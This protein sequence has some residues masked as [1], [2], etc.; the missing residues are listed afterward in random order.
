MQCYRRLASAWLAL[1]LIG[2]SPADEPA[3]DVSVPPDAAQVDNSDALFAP[4]RVLAIEITLP[5]DDWDAL[6]NQTRTLTDIL[7]GDCLAQP[8]ADV[9]TYFQGDISID[10]VATTAVGVRKKGFLGSLSTSK[11][12]LKVRFDKFVEGQHVSGPVKR[13]T[14]NNVRQD[15]SKLNTCL[16]YAVFAAAGVPAPRCGFAHV[17]VNGEDLGLYVHIDSTKKPF[18]RRHF[19]SDEGNLYEGTISDFTEGWRGTFQKKTNREQAD[20]VDIGALVEALQAFPGADIATLSQHVDLEAFYT[21]WALEVLVGHWDSYSGN[22]NN[23][24]FYREPDGPFHFLPWGADSTFAP[25]EDHLGNDQFP[26]AVLAHGVI[27][28]HLYADPAGRAAFVARLRE[29]LDTVWNEA[30]LLGELERMSDQVLTHT[31]GAEKQQAV[32]DY[33]R[34]KDFMEGRRT[35]IEASLAEDGADWDIP[36]DEPL[37]CWEPI[38]TVDATFTAE[39]GTAG[40]ENPLGLGAVTTATFDLYGEPQTFVSTGATA[41]SQTDENGTAGTVNLIY[42]TA[43]GRI[44]VIS[45][46]A[47]ADRMVPG[48]TIGLDDFTAGGF[49]LV[50]NPPYTSIDEFSRLGHATLELDAADTTEGGT[51]SGRIQGTIFDVTP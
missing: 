24:Y 26:Q 48:A 4:Y 22:R 32:T 35:A 34:V 18:L 12:S 49:R 43:E 25:L 28:H 20:F 51:V 27:A 17:T 36:L 40:A 46:R 3:A 42:A 2:C 47:A 37:I 39:W 13:L 16:S 45:A 10:G 14:L 5:P 7:A 15:R 8:A 30:W 33:I 38:G 41:G 19:A 1:A 29:L 31:T 6:R 23:Y 9:F 11:P 44:E 21:F 50:L